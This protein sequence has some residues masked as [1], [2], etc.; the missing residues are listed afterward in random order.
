MSDDVAT[1]LVVVVLL[2]SVGQHSSK[3]LIGPKA[4]SFQIGSG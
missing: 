1:L 3:R 2:V 4:P